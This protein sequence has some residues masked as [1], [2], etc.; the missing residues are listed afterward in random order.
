MT[1]ATTEINVANDTLELHVNEE[2][3]SGASL[4]PAVAGNL[5]Y[6]TSNSNVVRVKD[7]K[8]VAVGVGSAVVTV[9]FAGNDIY[10]AAEDK[11][12]G[13]SVSLND[14]SVG[15]YADPIELVIGR[16]YNITDFVYTTPEGLDVTSKSNNESVVTVDANGIVTAIEL[17]QT[18]I[19]VTVGG[20]GFYALNTTDVTV[21]VK[22]IPT[23]IIANATLNMSVGDVA[24]NVA[25]LKPSVAGNLT[26]VS[27]NYNVVRVENSKLI[28]VANGTALVNVNFAGN[29]KYEAAISKV[30]NVTVSLRNVGVSVNDADLDLV[31]KDTFKLIA[32][33]VPEGLNVSYSSTNESVGTVDSNGTVTAVG[34]G[35]ATIVVSVGDDKVYAVNSTNVTVTVKKATSITAADVST[36]YKVNKNLVITLKDAKGKAIANA[37]VTVNLNGAKTYTTDKNGQVKVSTKGLAPKA[38]TAKVTFNGNDDYAKSTKDVKVTVKKATPKLTAKKKT[39][40]TSVKTKKYAIILKDN[41]GKAIKKAKVTLKVKGKTYK[42]TTNSKGK[43]VFKIKNL[44]KKG[45][46][47]A[48]IT[49]KGNKYYNKVSKKA[50]IKVIVTFKTVSKGSKDK[51]TVKEIQ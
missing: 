17:D 36:T 31:V 4:T 50:N 20:D 11:T 1:K 23:E 26:Y 44:K 39:F 27:G 30:I 45:T 24:S 6:T 42:T 14:A 8:I 5:T 28:A 22:K 46:F 51:S 15:V 34:T 48:T 13:V 40:K 49:Y 33:T 21:N 25:S 29:D 32:T 18:T 16:E 38:Y 3:D 47:K 19:T 41:T 37:K 10:V 9:S 7:G 35:K 43:A 2:V 12:I